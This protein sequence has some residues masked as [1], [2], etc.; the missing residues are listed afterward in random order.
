MG[1]APTAFGERYVW[2]YA[3]WPE[4]WNGR[5]EGLKNPSPQGGTGSSPVSGT[6]ESYDVFVR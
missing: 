1:P 5:H 6:S 3:S 4:W 2:Y